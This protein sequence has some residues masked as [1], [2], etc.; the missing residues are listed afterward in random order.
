MELAVTAKR[1]RMRMVKR[2]CTATTQGDRTRGPVAV[3]KP[4]CRAPR[5]PW[6]A[7]ACRPLTAKL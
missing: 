5:P 6:Q 7:V 4:S 2:P 3:F 1:A